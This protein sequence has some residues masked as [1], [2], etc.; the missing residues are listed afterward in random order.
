MNEELLKSQMES[1]AK[2]QYGEVL[3]EFIG[4]KID[5][6]NKI[7][8]IKT[9]EELVGRQEAA[10]ILKEIFR[11]LEANRKTEGLTTLKNEYQ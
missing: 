2:S 5:S 7:G 8:D 9:I 4:Q 1:L 6:L 10:K 3:L 11:F